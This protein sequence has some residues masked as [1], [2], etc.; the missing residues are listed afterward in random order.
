MAAEARRQKRR[1][2]F[3][4]TGVAL[5]AAGILLIFV[6]TLPDIQLVGEEVFEGTVGPGK[7][8]APINRTGFGFVEL[9]G[10]VLPCRLS[11]HAVTA[12]ELMTVN[13]TQVLPEG[14]IDC[15]NTQ[16]VVRA[17]ATHVIAYNQDATES[18]S[19]RVSASFFVAPVLYAWLL[20]P[21]FAVVAVGL[22]VVGIPFL[23]GD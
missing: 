14:G 23:R 3:I 8:V 21:G 1:W 13:E 16:T 4:L 9:T 22:L 10:D 15:Q 17:E 11:F 18:L 6:S 2:T 12:V 5:V 7:H 20:I 19:Y